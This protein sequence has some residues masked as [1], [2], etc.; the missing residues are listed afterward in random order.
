M[1]VWNKL[2]EIHI[3]PLNRDLIIVLAM[4]ALIGVALVTIAFTV[5]YSL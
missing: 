3:N 4:G 5:F 1:K 2:P